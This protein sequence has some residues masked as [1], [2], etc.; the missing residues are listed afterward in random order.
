[1]KVKYTILVTLLTALYLCFELGFNARLLDVVG[2]AATESQLHDIERY[3]RVLSGIAVALVVLQ[4][5]LAKRARS[6]DGSPRSMAIV[7]WCLVTVGV[8][9][10][11]LQ[12]FVNLVVDH[13]SPSFRRTALNIVLVQRALV[14]GGVELDG[15]DDDPRLFTR[16]EGK[17]FLALFPVMATSVERL[18]EK[19][20][21][22]KLQL[23]SRQIADRLGGPAG[24]HKD[25]LQAIERTQ[26]QWQRY[27]KIPGAQ[28]INAEIAR[29]QD[30]AWADYIA[31]LGKR[32]WT[33]AT[34]P[35]YGR[36]SVRRK[37][38]S[39]VPVSAD[40]DLSDE[41]GFRE[42]VAGQ[43]RR[44]TSDG[45]VTV[46]GTKVPA[47]LGWNEFLAHAAVQAEVRDALKLPASITV[48]ASYRSAQEFERDFFIPSVKE[49][50]RKQLLQYEAPVES[51]A[52]GQPNEQSGR[53]AA[54]A[55]LVPP[56]ALFFSLL[57]AVGHISKLAYLV[58]RLTISALPS[59]AG[60]VRYLW[61]APLSVLALT[62]T[63]LSLLDNVVTESRLYAYMR[64]QM[65]SKDASDVSHQIR[66]RLLSNAL[67]VVA[68]GQGYGYPLNE[69]VRTRL[70]GNITYG[71]NPP[72]SP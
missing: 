17:A 40:W 16:P 1:M 63:A 36:D 32:G 64:T 39:K 43:V 55:A 69:T 38:R 33:P 51:F 2:S 15:L 50:A 9:F 70:L 34:V 21:A 13:S 54:R 29:Q 3:G 14:K 22:A 49:L 72:S 8:V 35:S 11:T 4:W 27:R 25:Y 24:Q 59:L 66:T 6:A 67:H 47:G 12:L 18:D 62:W 52:D 44:R 45:G 19:I 65:V 7:F 57:G 26:A 10:G 28:D 5:S 48:R 42:A 23:I 68:V 58:L 31:E 37:V 53:D 56:I 60:R 46:R 30:R 20:S 71:Y 41:I 61:V